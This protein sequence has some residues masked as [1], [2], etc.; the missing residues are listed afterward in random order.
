MTTPT[1]DWPEALIPQSCSLNPRK[2][3]RIYEGMFGGPPQAVGVPGHQWMLS[4]NLPEFPSDTAES[5]AA[6]A[7]TDQL[8]GGTVFV[9]A[10]NF[11][12][13]EPLGSLRGSPTTSGSLAIGDTTIALSGGS[14]KNLLR[15]GSFELDSNADGL[16]DGWT[17]YT[18]GTS[19]TVT[20]S[21]QSS[22]AI[23][24]HGTYWQRSSSVGLGG[25][26]GDRH[27]VYRTFTPT[28]VTLTNTAVSASLRVSSGRP[29]SIHVQ[30]RLA[31]ATVESF[32]AN[33]T[34]TS[35]TFVRQS[36]EFK[37]TSTYDELR[38]FFWQ[39]VGSGGTDIIDVDAVM[40]EK[41]RHATDFE[42][43]GGD[44]KAGDMLGVG[45]Q[46]FRVKSDVSPDSAGAL[47]VPVT[48]PVRAAISSG[49]AVTLV[50]PTA[51]FMA[52]NFFNPTTYSPGTLQSAALELVEVWES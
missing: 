45:G 9:R 14:S 4:C 12:R 17:A 34:S 23:A 39:S 35:F 51:T 28:D 32:T 1:I 44:L 24:P 52:P 31:G 41:S 3:G 6:D 5:G 48:T 38:V 2:N 26:S 25:T 7:F 20:V 36:L 21:R 47:S 37:P 43:Y 18:F 22:G 10:W 11:A 50:R 8:S 29:Y 30:T 16:S 15:Y 19:G 49:A 46:L 27:G 33:F 40:V 13:P 42:P